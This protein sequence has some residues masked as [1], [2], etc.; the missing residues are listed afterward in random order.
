[1]S[2]YSIFLVLF[3]LMA[4]SPK[5]TLPDFSMTGYKFGE[6]PPVNSTIVATV[7]PS[8]GND[9]ANI[10]AAIAQ[11]ATLTPNEAGFRGAIQLTPG[12]YEITQTLHITASGIVLTG[13][14]P[15]GTDATL[16]ATY[17][18]QAPLIEVGIDESPTIPWS[19]IQSVPASSFPLGFTRVPVPDPAAFQVGDAVVLTV[20]PNQAWAE[21][22]GMDQLSAINTN[23]I[24]W[25]PDSYHIGYQRIVQSVTSTEVALDVG[26]PVTIDPAY[27]SVQLAP[28]SFPERIEQA[29]VEDLILISDYD[30][31]VTNQHPYE[32]EGVYYSSD[33]NH[34]FTAIRF[35][36]AAHAW[37]RN[38]ETHHFGGLIFETRAA[39][40]NISLINCSALDPVSLIT[41]SRRYGFDLGGQ[42]GLVI[43][44]TTRNCRHDYAL[45]SRTAGPN[46]FVDCSGELSTAISEPHHRWA[47]GVLYDN[48]MVSG[49]RAVIATLNRG[50]SGG[51]H[52]WAGAN[53]VFWNCGAPLFIM[54]QA[55]TTFTAMVGRD[56]SIPPSNAVSWWA[57]VFND[58]NGS[59]SIVEHSFGLFWDSEPLLESIDARYPI[60]SL[61]HTQKNAREGYP[62][63]QADLKAIQDLLFGK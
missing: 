57:T 56:P 3:M 34:A 23:A 59:D 24:D 13:K 55:P 51:G 33:E 9:T 28:Y 6:M 14:N 11:V 44:G 35:L 36:A 12:V 30:A 45:A 22:L 54:M 47:T 4:P 17:Q 32:E 21:M 20:I 19:T 40:K 7:S 2:V 31:S 26:I 63:A 41:G 29:G 16:H 5:P 62:A 43:G 61:Y 8:A 46:A 48:V 58:L 39:S 60:D 53:S 15:G 37:A 49:T 52:G 50:T 1:M 38:V 18:N 27:Y 10:Q 42:L 25:N